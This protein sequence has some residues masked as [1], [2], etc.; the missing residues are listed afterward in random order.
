MHSILRTWRGGGGCLKHRF[1]RFVAARLRF[2][3]I[4]ID[5]ADSPWGHV[6]LHGTHNGGVRGG[7]LPG[8]MHQ[9]C[10][11]QQRVRFRLR[12]KAEANETTDG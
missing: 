10:L 9:T 3:F 11:L 4:F 1:R 8:G 6:E 7:G 2:I 12:E 5:A